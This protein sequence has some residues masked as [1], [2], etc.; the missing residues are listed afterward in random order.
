MENGMLKR[1]VEDGASAWIAW[2]RKNAHK[3]I[4]I[5]H[6]SGGYEITRWHRRYVTSHNFVGDTLEEAFRDA[7]TKA[8]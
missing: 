8:P 3:E 7:I 5:T 4:R 6:D 2:L 1:Q